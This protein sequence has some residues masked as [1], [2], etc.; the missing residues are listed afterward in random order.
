M[1]CGRSPGVWPLGALLS[2]LV[3]HAL[4]AFTSLA[5]KSVTVDEFGHLPAGVYLLETGDFEHAS[6]NPPLMNLL[7]ALPVQLVRPSGSPSLTAPGAR[8]LSE[9][10]GS[11]FWRDG[12]R[13]MHERGG[14][15]HRTFVAARGAS[16]AM[17]MLLA[18]ASFVWARALAP[19]RPDVAGVVAAGLVLFSPNMLAHG[20]LVTTDAGAATAITLAFYGVWRFA[21]RPRVARALWLGLA[22]GAAQLVK[23]SALLLLPLAAVQLA[24]AWTR[25]EPAVRSR[26]AAGGALAFAFALLVVHAGYGF[27]DPLPALGDRE[28]RSQRMQAVA[29]TLPASL[30]V[31][32]PGHYLTALDRQARGLE[33]GDPSYLFGHSYHGGRWDYFL[34]LLA[35]KT[36]L[37]LL[38]LALW[39]GVRAVRSRKSD[40][41]TRDAWTYLLFPA[42]ALL[43]VASLGS[44]KQIGLRMVLP[45]LPLAWIFIAVVLAGAPPARLRDA[46]L[47]FGVAAVALVS[48]WIHPDYLPY[49]NMAFG[50]S[51][52][53]HRVA[54]QSNYDWGQDLIGLHEKIEANGGGPVQ[55]LYFGRVDPALYGIEYS[56]PDIRSIRPGLLAVSATLEARGYALYDHGELVRL[57]SPLRL[58]ASIGEPIATIGHSIRLYRVLPRN[59]SEESR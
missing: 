51:A 6:L 48:V 39:A 17:V 58:G 25:S 26:I 10:K 19:A 56:V 24:I 3:L 38:A 12:Y 41:S 55:L 36:P 9:M 31:P 1:G 34:V 59:L 2:M 22:L 23:F 18:V 28:F 57:D 29:A 27:T 20:R 44:E 53:G 30:R 11:R 15:Y 52:R 43:A 13:F 42:L 33:H 46:A 49:Y 35:A 54:L 5:R 45:I 21:R 8:R 47:A 7:S 50:G 16:V 40:P 14:D 37:P 32:I 4:L